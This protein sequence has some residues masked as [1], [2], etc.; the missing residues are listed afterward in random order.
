[1]ISKLHLRIE[2][3][4]V[5]DLFT[6]EVLEVIDDFNNYIWRKKEKQL[7]GSKALIFRARSNNNSKLWAPFRDVYLIIRACW[8]SNNSYLFVMVYLIRRKVVHLPSTQL[9]LW[10]PAQFGPKACRPMKG[11]A[12]LCPVSPLCKVC[13]RVE[14]QAW[15]EAAN[16]WMFS[17]PEHLAVSVP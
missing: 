10:R 11:P 5:Q 2:A 4:H 15:M 7:F 1:M 3:T 13:A 14:L 6:I 8:V 16:T 17:S 12:L 9:H